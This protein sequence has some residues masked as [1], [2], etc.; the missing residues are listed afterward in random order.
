LTCWS[1]ETFNL[2]VID[3]GAYPLDGIKLC[4]RLRAQ[5]AKPILLLSYS[6]NRLFI[7]KAFEAEVDA[8]IAKPASPSL[9]VA[10]ARSLVRR[11]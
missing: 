2:T 5:T 3:V 10:R 9:L 11:L 4:Y 7:L 6:S 1:E 8:Y